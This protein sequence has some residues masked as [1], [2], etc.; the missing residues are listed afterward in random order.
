MRPQSIALRRSAPP[1]GERRCLVPGRLVE[2]VYLGE[3]WEY[4]VVPQDSALRLKVTTAPVDVYEVGE[5][6]WL[7]FDPG[8][9]ALVNE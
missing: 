9:M 3:F 7:E 8:Q 1:P 4:I 2:R 5:E 6:V